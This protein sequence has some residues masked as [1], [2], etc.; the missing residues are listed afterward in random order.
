MFNYEYKRQEMTMARSSSLTLRDSDQN[1]NF[2]LLLSAEPPSRRESCLALESGGRFL[3]CWS[4]HAM[5]SEPD[6]DHATKY[7]AERKKGYVSL[8]AFVTNVCT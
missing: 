4:V 8:C 5:R 3:C 7:L 2:L 6:C 1:K